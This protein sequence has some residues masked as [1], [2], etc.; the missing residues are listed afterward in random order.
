MSFTQEQLEE[1]RSFLGASEV[2]AALGLS[3][4]KTPYQLWREKVLGDE[5]D[6]S[7]RLAI[8]IGNALEPVILERFTRS[9]GLVVTDRQLVITD[10]ANPWRRATLDGRASDGNLVEAKSVG[11][12]HPDEWGEEDTD[13]IPMEYF[14][15]TQRQLSLDTAEF[16]Y[17]PVIVLNR[18]ERLY[19]IQRDNDFIADM[20]ERERQF[21]E[22]V[23][24]KTPPDPISL[25]DLKLRYPTDNG[26]SIQADITVAAA[27]D[28]LKNVK[29][30]LKTLE[31]RE[32]ELKI[33]IAGFMGDATT[34][35]T[36]MGETLCTYK[37]QNRSGI[38]S[39]SLRKDH[40]TIADA[41]TKVSSFRVLRLK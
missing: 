26:M 39:K 14:C 24:N 40:P 2:S 21:M 29:A 16:C 33:S 30:E 35:V 38:D 12:A 23:W 37:S 11:F 41:Y 4:Y 7:E 10:P 18:T 15:Q 17:V 34:L 13:M 20:I 5:V 19:K 31:A 27:V 3:R 22:M 36:S 9:T 32:E 8:E 25:A 6:I 28:H 1:R